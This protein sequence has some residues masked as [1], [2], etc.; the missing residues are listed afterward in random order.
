[1][2]VSDQNPLYF[3]LAAERI[4]GIQRFHEFNATLNGTIICRSVSTSVD[5]NSSF[6]QLNSNFCSSIA[7]ILVLQDFKRD[8]FLIIEQDD[9]LHLAEINVADFKT[10]QLTIPIF[11]PCC[12]PK[13]SQ[14][15]NQ[16]L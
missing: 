3:L 7:R 4:V 14:H 5:S 12:L 13:D 11:S 6:F 15:Q 2:L 16:H 10:F 1:M 9:I 8:T